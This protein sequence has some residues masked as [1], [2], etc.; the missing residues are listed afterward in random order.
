MRPVGDSGKY[1]VTADVQDG[2]IRV[3][4]TALDKDDAFVNFLDL[5]GVVVGPDLKPIDIGMK[6]TAP[7]RYVAELQGKERGNYFV[8]LNPGP[9]KAPLRVGVNVSYSDEYRERSTNDAL[10]HELADLVPVGGERGKFL[11]VSDAGADGNARLAGLLKT[12]TFRHD[13]AKATSS[14]DIWPW[15][16][17]AAACLF[18]GDVF[19]RRVS[20]DWSWVRPLTARLRDRWLGR[21]TR[22]EVV[23]VLDRLR[24]RKAEVG[25]QIEQRRAAARFEPVLPAR[26]GESPHGSASPVAT[27]ASPL[28]TV[29]A[30]LP[31]APCARAPPLRRSRRAIPAGC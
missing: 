16:V 15:L 25:D 3:V 21:N 2:N 1:T 23:A 19:T 29:N 6:Q 5:G 30:E 8:M 24:S 11:E 12:D 9:G 27:A 7:G 28:D 31:K 18:F 20:I 10:L 17:M 14:R 22:E 4:V 26:S 13:L